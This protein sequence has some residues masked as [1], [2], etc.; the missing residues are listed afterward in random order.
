MTLN[1][2]VSN[3]GIPMGIPMEQFILYRPNIEFE[4]KIDNL[5]KK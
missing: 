1:V 4:V 2:P 3:Q 5:G